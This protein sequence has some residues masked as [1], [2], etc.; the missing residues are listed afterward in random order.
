MIN[1]VL[2]IGVLAAI[3]GFTIIALA[4][5]FLH[6][7]R[8]SGIFFGIVFLIFGTFFIWGGIIRSDT[9]VI[10][11]GDSGDHF[12]IFLP[13]FILSLFIIKGVLDIRNGLK[14][15]KQESITPNL[16]FRSKFQIIVAI[17]VT[18]FALFLMVTFLNM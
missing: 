11:L 1:L 9:I 18:I 2:I 15:L 16:R 8:I 4:V 6:E 12:G 10:N 5:F 3:V 13:F 7:N 17:I 14:N